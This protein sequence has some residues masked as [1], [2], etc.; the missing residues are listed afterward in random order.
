[1]AELAR[2]IYATGLDRHYLQVIV[3]GSGRFPNGAMA[4]GA[5]HRRSH[6]VWSNWGALEQSPREL[7]AVDQ[8][9]AVPVRAT[10]RR[11]PRQPNGK[12]A[13]VTH[14]GAGYISL[15]QAAAYFSVS[16]RTIRRWISSRSLPHYYIGGPVRG[17]LLFRKGEL[18]RWA[19]KHKNGFPAYPERKALDDMGPEAL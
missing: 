10:H 1:M 19:R 6:A 12:V 2:F 14:V 5:C 17:K 15:A 7:D 3:A 13:M 16:A 11:D 18:D 8:V 4:S 9:Y